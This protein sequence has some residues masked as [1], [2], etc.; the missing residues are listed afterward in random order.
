MAAVRN[1]QEGVMSQL[2]RMEKLIDSGL[3]AVHLKIDAANTKIEV[4]N[5]KEIRD[6][7]LAMVRLE[8][9]VKIYAALAGFVGM[10]IGG[11]LVKFVVH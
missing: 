7:Q 1:W 5:S 2:E 3:R 8:T 4:L 10:A 11:A 6:L 9:Q